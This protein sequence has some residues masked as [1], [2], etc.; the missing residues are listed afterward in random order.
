MMLQALSHTGV[1]HLWSLWSPLQV[2]GAQVPRAALLI[3]P[4]IRHRKILQGDPGHQ[5]PQTNTHT[6]TPPSLPPSVSPRIL[7]RGFG[8]IRV[9]LEPSGR[10]F[11]KRAPPWQS[12]LGIRPADLGQ[13]WL[14][15][16]NGSQPL[17]ICQTDP[18]PP[19]SSYPSPPLHL[20]SALLDRQV[21]SGQHT[22]LTMAQV[23][24]NLSLHSL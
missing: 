16:Y 9:F 23:Q 19:T 4:Y 3:H 20:S 12:P 7:S 14:V 11:D 18:H 10:A 21:C 24:L 8:G 2:F 6:H 5:P 13:L 1:T 17:G 22:A 15:A